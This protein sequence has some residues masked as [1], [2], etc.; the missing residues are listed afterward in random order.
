MKIQIEG[1]HLQ[2]TDSIQEHVHKKIDHL[3]KF[4]NGINSIHVILNVEDQRRQ[5]AELVCTV[6][7]GQ[8]LVASAAAGDLYR[9]IDDAVHKMKE[10]LKKHKERLRTHKRESARFGRVEAPE[11]SPQE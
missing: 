8:P 5:V 7:R 3:D 4:F 9:A 6:V 1:R 10:H 11:E 2:I